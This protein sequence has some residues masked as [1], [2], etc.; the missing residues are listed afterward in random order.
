MAMN[1]LVLGGATV[2][3]MAGDPIDSPISSIAGI[4]LGALIGSSIEVVKSNRREHLP[5]GASD[6][7]VDHTKL[8]SR[9]NRA[10]TEDGYAEE[11]QRQAKRHD[12][13]TRYSGRR[14]IREVT[15]EAQKN[16]GIVTESM[17]TAAVDRA[18]NSVS[19]WESAVLHNFNSLSNMDLSETLGQSGAM[20]FIRGEYTADELSNL[21]NSGKITDEHFKILRRASSNEMISSEVKAGEINYSSKLRTVDMS[22]VQ[23]KEVPN[24]GSISIDRTASKEEKINALRDYLSQTLGHDDAFAERFARNISNFY[25][26]AAIDISNSDI[27][28]RMPNGETIKDLIPEKKNGILRYSKNG[29][30]YEGKLY[31]PFADSIGATLGGIELASLS[32]DGKSVVINSSITSNA[33]IDGF[34][35]LEVAGFMGHVEGTPYGKALEKMNSLGAYVGP[36]DGDNVVRAPSLDTKQQFSSSDT[37]KIVRMKDASSLDDQ[38][39]IMNTINQAMIEQTGLST[40]PSNIRQ[41]TYSVSSV[42]QATQAI[43]GIAPH[44]ERSTGTVSRGTIIDLA[45]TTHEDTKRIAQASKLLVEQGHGHNFSGAIL[46]SIAGHDSNF[47]R[48]IGSAVMGMVLEDGKTEQMLKGIHLN[49]PGTVKL[50]QG[51]FTGTEE[52]IA[53]LG[54]IQN[55]NSVSYKGGESIGFFGGKEY[56]IPKTVD[57][58]TVSRIENTRDGYKFVGKNNI[59]TDTDSNSGIKI[60]NDV[61]STSTHRTERDFALKEIIDRF[62]REGSISME[63]GSV[64]VSSKNTRNLERHNQLQKV[65]PEGRS[66]FSPKEFRGAIEKFVEQNG[67][68]MDVALS[69]VRN[70]YRD[71]NVRSEDFKTGYTLQA[72]EVDNFRDKAQINRAKNVIGEVIT[73]SG[74]DV[75][76]ELPKDAPQALKDLQHS[77]NRLSES[78]L[79]SNEAGKEVKR[80]RASLFAAKS[81]EDAKF[82]NIA[83]GT[84]LGNLSQA[85][86]KAIKRGNSMTFNVALGDGSSVPIHI[87]KDKDIS[88]AMAELIK[89]SSKRQ[90]MYSAGKISYDQLYNA[91]KA[92]YMGL[93]SL[94]SK[95]SLYNLAGLRPGTA[96]LTG[97]SSHNQKMSWMAMDRFDNL[98]NSRELKDAL[99]T[100]NMDAIYEAKARGMELEAGHE[101]SHVFD[102]DQRERAIQI[103]DLF[104]KDE[105]KRL[106]A[107]ENGGSLSHIKPQDG[108]LNITLP[109]PKGMSKEFKGKKSLSIPILDSNISGYAELPN[110]KDAT[111]E[112]TKMRRNLLLTLSDYMNAKGVGGVAEEF[113]ATAYMNAVKEYRD[114]QKQ[115]GSSLK[116]AAAGRNYRNAS[117]STVQPLNE[118]QQAVFDAGMNKDKL[119]VFVSEDAASEYGLDKKRF[120]YQEIGDSGM[121]RVID[122]ETKH[123]VQGLFTREPATG[124][125]SVLST[126]LIVDRNMSK[127]MAVGMDANIMKINSGDFDD[128]KA[129]LSVLDTKSKDFSEHNKEMAKIMK[130]QA[131]L[132]KSH[133]AAITKLTPKLNEGNKKITNILGVGNV[134]QKLIDNIM[135]G[136]ERDI[137]APRVTAFHQLVE[138]SLKRAKDE[139]MNLLSRT[140]MDEAARKAAV[141]EIRAR[142]YIADQAAYLMQ[143]NTLKSVRLANK[144]GLSVSLM[145]QIEEF[146]AENRGKHANYNKLGDVIGDF[147]GSLYQHSD[148]HVGKSIQDSINTVRKSVG[149]YGK[150]V[151]MDATGMVGSEWSRARSDAA[152]VAAAAR[153]SPSVNPEVLPFEPNSSTI[154]KIEDGA[155][156]VLDTLKHNKNKLILGAAGL[157]GLAMISR[158][159]TPN[160]SSPMYNSPVARTSPVLEGRTSETSYIKDWGNDPNSVTIN[161]QVIS[162]ISDAR[163]KQ[164]LRGLIQGDTNQRSTVTFNNRN[165]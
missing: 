120:Q 156:S 89:A 143:E 141:E 165:Y 140:K 33:V 98:T 112:A 104:D 35:N 146:M 57:S 157:A 28:I 124:P 39:R 131:E 19:K 87:G 132:I 102:A 42:D 52:Q 31:Q 8:N 26:G 22:W 61:K 160:P 122:K 82:S 94:G 130:R 71:I 38:R 58:F 101:F 46:A 64:V 32:S 105:A 128:D 65:L 109:V 84:V 116:K 123:P 79:D 74:L 90:N 63:N 23:N 92:D 12:A 155:Y 51:A 135:S 111:K 144:D 13:M 75:S 16:K 44:P 110:G 125:N 136:K 45:N 37:G 77:F 129:L 55:G 100:L 36:D 113:A 149:K 85:H 76:G 80:A 147:M 107:F 70:T 81:I 78:G 86:D 133:K 115:T 40:I 119:R 48:T 30:I 72:L 163:I 97:E 47:N 18:N 24:I 103:E 27:S 54:Q 137:E 91:I 127:G 162:G 153:N 20:K 114:F 93:E 151:L 56:K 69:K 164:N 49:T 96:A 10:L 43:A 150:E 60:F 118:A 117:Y 1:N 138:G 21:V 159:E 7:R 9:A 53:K 15:A 108:I 121:F 62:E 14:S 158:S 66:R 59:V 2:G 106:K 126:E 139:E 5:R 148:D 29:N 11:M 73:N 152:A 6:I 99:T 95:M 41:R 145:E 17:R 68:E 34:T 88:S 3:F 67:A 134:T 50:G 83:L 25:P 4:G 142:Y 161:G 154:N